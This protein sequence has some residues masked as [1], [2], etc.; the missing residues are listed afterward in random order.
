MVLYCRA[1]LTGLPACRAGI[2]FPTSGHVSNF[3]LVERILIAGDALM[4]VKINSLAG[5]LLPLG[6]SGAPWYDWNSYGSLPIRS[7]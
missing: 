1:R 2:C 5:P 4:T 3:R 6:L 7:G